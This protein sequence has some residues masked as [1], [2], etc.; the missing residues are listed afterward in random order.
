MRLRTA[1]LIPVKSSVRAK[2]RLAALLDQSARQRLALAMLEDVLAAVV[3]A[4]G[5]LVDEVYVVTSDP[6]AM[7]AA[8]SAGATILLSSSCPIQGF[9]YIGGERGRCLT[10]LLSWV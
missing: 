7:K 6:D 5:R 3:P 10:F 2:G 1:I 9:S 8:R 4:I